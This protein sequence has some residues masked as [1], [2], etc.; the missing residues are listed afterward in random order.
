[1]SSS[2]HVNVGH[3]RPVYKLHP[4]V[5]FGVLDHY[6]RR[7]DNQFRVLGALLG[8]KTG[9]GEVVIKNSFPVPHTET[10]DS[11]TLDE[12]YL[13]SML[14]LHKRVNPKEVVVGWYSTGSE[15]TYVTSLVHTQFQKLTPFPV[16]V[17]V[18]V[19]CTDSRMSIKAY[20][21][22]QF[23]VESKEVIYRFE[24]AEL[25]LEAYEGEKIGVDALIN[26]ETEEERLDAPAR[27]L[28]DFENLEVALNNLLNS[29]Q[30][31]S[32]YVQSV[33]DGKVAG[34]ENLGRAIAHALSAIPQLDSETFERM[35][36]SNVQDLLL[37]MYLSNL[38]RM[39][40]ALA[41]KIHNLN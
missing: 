19:A 37:I 14:E 35:F 31:V 28:S 4:V 41:D 5:V 15:V 2:L 10:E 32:T 17:T 30:T 26:G 25:E 36:C 1:M 9:P 13:K 21:G 34:D 40:L 23:T 27:I 20:R 3:L 38:T 12:G 39:Q 33:V 18:D 7:A 24:N 16:H 8:E 11:V 29:I 6:K 22:K